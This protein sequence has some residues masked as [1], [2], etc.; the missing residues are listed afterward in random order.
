MKPASPIP[1]IGSVHTGRVVKHLP[2]GALL[3]LVS[4]YRGL[5]H[6]SHISWWK[7][8]DAG[9]TRLEMGEEL[10]VVVLELRPSKST[11]KIY[12]ALGHRELTGNPWETI[13]AVHFVGE[14]ISAEVIQLLT[15]GAVVQFR[16]GFRALVHLSELSWTER[17]PV[18]AELLR[19]GD[20]ID[21][22]IV[23]IDPAKMRI[24]ASYRRAR[25]SPWTLFLDDYPIGSTARGRA[26]SIKPYGAFVMLAN[27]CTGLL[28]KNRCLGTPVALGDSVSVA[29]AKYD[30]ARQRIEFDQAGDTVHGG[31]N[32][33]G[34]VS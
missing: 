26:V 5:L 1:E 9:E 14:R 17:K 20:R 10:E 6:R 18:P 25:V 19:L 30:P 15:Y 2:H 13:S 22:V 28:H 27:G 24:Q 3:E 29:I 32:D 7:R 16:S 31:N 33:F 34:R 4:G 12:L 23:T 11:D 21:V 8:F